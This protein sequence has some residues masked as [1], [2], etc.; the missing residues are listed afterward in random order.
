MPETVTFVLG[1]EIERDD[2]KFLVVRI[3]EKSLVLF[4]EPSGVMY[5][6]EESYVELRGAQ[7]EV[8]FVVLFENMQ[9]FTNKKS[10]I[11]GLDPLTWRTKWRK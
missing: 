6:L 1:Q 3:I 2:K 8:E 10:T 4:E 11:K 7:G 9:P 5:T